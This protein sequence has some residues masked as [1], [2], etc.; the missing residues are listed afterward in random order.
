MIVQSLS[1]CTLFVTELTDVVFRVNIGMMSAK[2]ILGGYV[3]EAN[4]AFDGVCF[5]VDVTVGPHFLGTIEC[6]AADVT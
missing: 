6:F 2:G 5:F 1:G 4:F 3:G